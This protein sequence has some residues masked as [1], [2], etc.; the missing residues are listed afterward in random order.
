MHDELEVHGFPVDRA[1]PPSIAGLA[2]EWDDL[3]DRS[4]EPCPWL[5]PGWIAAWWRA[6]GRGRL[7][8]TTLRRADRLAA[9]AP[10]ARHRHRLVSPANYHTPAFELVGEDDDAVAEVARTLLA[11]RPPS[12]R[13]RFAA[14]GGT[15]VLALRAAARSR[16]YR[17]VERTLERSP[18]VDTAPGW[19]AYHG[20]L[21][22]KLRR[23]L[24][25]RLRRLQAEGRVEVTVA[26]GRRDLDDLLA[27]TLRVEG[28]AWKAGRG[29]AIASDGATAG[30]YT[31][32]A[33]WAAARGT[34]RLAYLRLD[35]RA[36]AVD[37]AVEE[38]GHHYLLKTGY[39]PAVRHL[40][41]G[42]LLRVAMLER[43]FSS[44]QRSYELL[45]ADE[46]WKLAWTRS[47]RERVELRAFRPGPTGL[48]GWATAAY[49]RPLAARA[50]AQV[51]R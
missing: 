50:A 47:V 11:E 44:G 37:L 49:A 42:L 46:P 25:R 10:L 13:I 7:V 26:D 14:G 9:I 39:D 23:E 19:H 18:Y 6:F 22:A 35:G 3:V 41:P 29:T 17:T 40:A 45:G 33:R 43:A 32:V 30:F 21:D 4:P 27:E 15:S 5:R 28:L 2:G 48:A 38:G 8:L 36:L 16:G 34:L 20:G 12:L 24:R 31:D 1:R 51:G